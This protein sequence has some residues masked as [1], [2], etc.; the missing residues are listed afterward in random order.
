MTS[1]S[2]FTVS[3]NF[4]VALYQLLKMGNNAML[5]F[6]LIIM[7]LL[8]SFEDSDDDCREI[9]DLRTDSGHIS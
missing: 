1:L 5:I 8:D 4:R 3:L 6:K 7:D 9:L 2:R